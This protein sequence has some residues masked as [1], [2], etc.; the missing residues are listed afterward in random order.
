MELNESPVVLLLDPKVDP[1]QKDLPA[2]LFETGGKCIHQLSGL[3]T[4]GFHII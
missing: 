3:C 4:Y 1:L 2:T